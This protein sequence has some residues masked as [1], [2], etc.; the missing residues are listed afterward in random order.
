MSKSLELSVEEVL[1]LGAVDSIFF[2]QHFFPKTARQN[3]PPF[4]A[5]VWEC[6][7]NTERYV[8]LMI[9]RGGAKTTLVRLL[10][11]KCVSYSL[12]RTIMIVG[13]SQSHAER[14][15]RWLRLQLERNK[16]WTEFFSL[17][18]GQKWTDGEM[19]VENGV[20]E[21]ATWIVALGITGSTRGVN[22][23]DWRPA[24]IVVDDVV[25]EENSATPEQRKKI[26]D[27][28]LGALKESLSPRSETPTAKMVILQTPQ[29]FDDIAQQAAKDPQFKTLRFP[30]WTLET[31]NLPI[32]LRESAWP[33][34]WTSEELRAER[35]AAMRRNKLSIF[36][37]E[38]ECKLVTPETSVFREEW[39]NYYDDTSRPPLHEMWTVMAIDPVP[40]PSELQVKKGFTDKDFEAIVVV[41]RRKGEY[42]LLETSYNRG[43]DPKWTVAEFFRLASIYKPRK[44]VVESASYQRTLSWL[45]RQAMQKVGRYYVIEEF[46][47]KRRKYDR[48]VDGISGVA[49]NGQLY[50]HR[51]RHTEFQS[52][53]V[54]Y[55]N[56]KYDDVLEAVA[57]AL[58]VLQRGVIAD[59]STADIA[60]LSEDH[61][62][63]LE[64][65]RGA[66]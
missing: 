6:L 58:T 34:R 50:V 10:M 11:A 63:D 65:Y 12:F 51:L 39:L 28:V 61:I 4:H 66:P 35:E 41:G 36:S 14:S 57:V 26:Q 53:Y 60:M 16:R 59:D 23:D 42:W 62:P 38:W 55:S 37:K 33:A 52:Q 31:E 7:E 3:P 54:H 32:E 9:F 49:S 56:V 18:K 43:H 64:D 13:K 20:D 44:I 21:E 1:N 48:I 47:D 24:L 22:Y 2:S 40:P 45:I 30:C 25:D 27:L 29:D 19:Q 17:R 46:D 5:K 15:V 8:N